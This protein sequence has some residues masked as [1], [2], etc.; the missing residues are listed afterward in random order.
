M[1]MSPEWEVYW[2]W[3]KGTEKCGKLQL[4]ISRMK[5]WFAICQALWSF[6]TF[7]SSG[8]YKHFFHLPSTAPSIHV[9]HRTVFLKLWC[10]S[11]RKFMPR[12]EVFC[13]E[14]GIKLEP[15]VCH[16]PRY[17]STCAVSA[18]AWS[19]ARPSCP[20]AW[21]VLPRDLCI[22]DTKRCFAWNLLLSLNNDT[23]PCVFAVAME[24]G[25][26]LKLEVVLSKH[27]NSA[28]LTISATFPAEPFWTSSGLLHSGGFEHHGPSFELCILAPWNWVRLEV[29]T[30]M[31]FFSVL[32]FECFW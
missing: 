24:M 32:A 8:P 9:S 21:P 14:L 27:H 30:S 13:Q 31:T 15:L 16:P 20:F 5:D 4:Q 26:K 7:C 22:R 19:S 28:M 17:L 2:T 23:R 6:S 25:G 11:Q 12:L 29:S 10:I 3:R 18:A 1:F